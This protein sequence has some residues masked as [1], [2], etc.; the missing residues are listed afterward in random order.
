MIAFLASLLRVC[1]RPLADVA[2]V[3]GAVLIFWLL[4]QI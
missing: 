3:L 2:L 4:S 1:A